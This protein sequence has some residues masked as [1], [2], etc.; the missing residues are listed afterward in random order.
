MRHHRT[1]K[2]ATEL[3]N[4]NGWGSTDD[5][6]IDQLYIIAVGATELQA[7]ATLGGRDFED[8]LQVACAAAAG[9]DLIVTRDPA[10]FAGSTV[11]VIAPADLLNR[12]NAGSW[13]RLP[14]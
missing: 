14:P 1:T 11:E 7:A 3:S 5:P 4:K 12:L 10:G 2:S 8:G 6:R 13:A 9:L